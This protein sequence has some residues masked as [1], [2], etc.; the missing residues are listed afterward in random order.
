MGLRSGAYINCAIRSGNQESAPDPSDG[1]QGDKGSM[2]AGRDLAGVITGELL[3]PVAE[4]IPKPLGGQ[5][6]SGEAR[7]KAVA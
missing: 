7:T 2:A 1:R 4:M 5:E 6:R 3:S